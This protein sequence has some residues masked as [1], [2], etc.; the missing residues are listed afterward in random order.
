M[1]QSAAGDKSVC[2]LQAIEGDTRHTGDTRD[3]TAEEAEVTSVE[4]E[5]RL[6][7]QMIFHIVC[8]CIIAEKS[9]TRAFSWL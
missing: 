4:V 2:I 7:L 8:S 1:L 5:W 3:N 6:E 9:P